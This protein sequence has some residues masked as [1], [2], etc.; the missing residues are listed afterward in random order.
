MPVPEKN[1]RQR[2]QT[3]PLDNVTPYVAKLADISLEQP[4]DAI[5]FMSSYHDFYGYLQQDKNKRI[6]ILENLKKAL[7]PGGEVIISDMVP[8][9]ISFDGKMHR[10]DKGLVL[11]EF[12]AAGYR[13]VA[14]SDMLRKPTLDDHKTIG[15]DKERFYTD[16]WLIKLAPSA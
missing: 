14:E 15:Y 8:E 3:R 1:I 12:I 13:L 10:I 5:M 2:L 16:R 7:K 11:A 4:V 6:Q 9:D